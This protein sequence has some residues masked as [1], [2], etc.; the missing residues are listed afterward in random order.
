[1]FATGH[2][3][4]TVVVAYVLDRGL[5]HFT[6]SDTT[7]FTIDVGV[8]YGYYC[9]AAMFTYRLRGRWWWS[10]IWAAGSSRSSWCRSRST[11]SFTSFG[12]LVTVGVGLALYPITRSRAVRTRLAAADLEAAGGHRRAVTRRRWPLDGESRRPEPES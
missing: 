4:A 11:A 12:H 8:S 6:D 7:R 10:W 9:I 1:M 3:L 5:I 2:V